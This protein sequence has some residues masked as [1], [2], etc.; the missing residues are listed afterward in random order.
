MQLKAANGKLVA[1]EGGG[2]N[3]GVMN[4]RT[5][6]D[7]PGVWE[8]I[9][10]APHPLFAEC[11][12]LYCEANVFRRYVSAQPDGSVA[13]NRVDKDNPDDSIPPH[14]KTAPDYWEAF[15]RHGAGA[16]GVAYQSLAF[17]TYLTMDVCSPAIEIPPGVS[18]FQLTCDAQTLGED[19]IFEAL[20]RLPPEPTRDQMIQGRMS[21]QGLNVTLPGMTRP[22]PWFEPFIAS[23]TPD[24]R[25]AVYAAKHAAGDTHI[26]YALSYNYVSG[27][28]YRYPIDGRDFTGDL[29]GFAELVHE[30]CAHG[31]RPFV[32]LASDGQG[33]AP[34]GGTYGWRWGMD[35]MAVV[36]GAFE[37]VHGV[38]LRRRVLFGGGFELLGPGGNWTP[39][40]LIAYYLQLRTY[41][42]DSGYTWLEL[43]QGYCKWMEDGAAC[44]SSPA[45]VSL[46]V[47]LQEYSQPLEDNWDGACQLAR[48][49]LGPSTYRG[50][51]PPQIQDDP[52]VAYYLRGDRPRGPLGIWAFEYDLYRFTRGQSSVGDVDDQR[53]RLQSLGYPSVG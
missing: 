52:Q 12:M 10:E 28:G 35:H 34:E 2:T 51:L 18:G 21:F 24:G 4:A 43:G 1:C 11:V 16:T 50:P 36:L 31:F 3:K 32:S 22:I 46:D 33:Y 15:I 26:L 30:G 13:C 39:D 38:D 17:G 42:G 48:R 29:D 44:W 37:Q 9:V 5:D 7:R 40:Q 14:L 23:L 19:Q 25:Q 53:Q 27:D 20:G 41:V 49:M 47:F 6:P 45:G 8:Q